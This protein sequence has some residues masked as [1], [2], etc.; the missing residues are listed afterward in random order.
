MNKF[1]VLLFAHN[2]LNNAVCDNSRNLKK[3]VLMSLYRESVIVVSMHLT[4]S[5]CQ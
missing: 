3:N 4:F 5:V 1:N 2:A